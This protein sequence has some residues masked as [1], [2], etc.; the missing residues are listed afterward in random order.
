MSRNASIHPGAI[1][2]LT[3]CGALLGLV[4][5]AAAVAAPKFHYMQLAPAASSTA[6]EIVIPV[7]THGVS[8]PRIRAGEIFFPIR[9]GWTIRR[10]FTTNAVV[11]IPDPG[12]TPPPGMKGTHI[13]DGHWSRKLK[14]RDIAL[15]IDAR[16]LRSLSFDPVQICR[17]AG[18]PEGGR[19]IAVNIPVGLYVTARTNRA[20]GKIRNGVKRRSIRGIVH[21]LG[22]IEPRVGDAGG[23]ARKQRFAVTGA[24]LDI[25]RTGGKCRLTYLVSVRVYANKQGRTRYTLRSAK[26]RVWR[27]T[28]P[29][30]EK[31][32]KRRYFGRF[33]HRFRMR[34]NRRERLW[35]EVKGRRVGG[36]YRLHSHC[37]PPKGPKP[38]L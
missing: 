8:E 32:G 4:W 21:C 17:N 37:R 24:R 19:R 18:L 10:G 12:V 3:T 30:S 20:S 25:T 36:I 28:I 22:V 5:P 35:V 33:S 13:R 16:R 29:V 15:R 1:A 31:F 14:P 34:K 38:A 11:M 27:Q 2:R 6:P 26:G 7:E 9:V 23:P